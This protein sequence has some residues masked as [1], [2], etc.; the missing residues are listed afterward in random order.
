MQYFNSNVRHYL[1]MK[2]LD[3]SLFKDNC[4][5][6]VQALFSQYISSYRTII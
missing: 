5:V 1:A 3:I 4:C 2:S 6:K